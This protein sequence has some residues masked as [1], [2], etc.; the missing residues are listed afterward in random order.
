M[1]TMEKFDTWE[2]VKT[3]LHEGKTVYWRSM[4]YVAST[5]FN[6]ALDA[7]EYNIKCTANG[8]MTGVWG[9]EKTPSDFFTVED[10]EMKLTIDEI[11]GVTDEEPQY[12]DV[13][14]ITGEVEIHGNAYERHV[15]VY[16]F[17]PY[18]FKDAESELF[19][20]NHWEEIEKQINEKMG[21]AK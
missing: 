9:E 21:E 12:Y 10:R 5:R 14:V 8:H 15:C 13:E 11:D 16:E 2:N 3:A 6:K 17:E 18:W 4:A 7:Q 20:N 19:F 1:K